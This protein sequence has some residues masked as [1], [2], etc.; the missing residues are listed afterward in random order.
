MGSKCEIST[1]VD[2]F[3]DVISSGEACITHAQA[4]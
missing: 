2:D 3:G 4:C 1:G